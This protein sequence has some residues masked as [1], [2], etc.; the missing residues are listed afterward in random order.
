FRIRREQGLSA[1][2]GVLAQV[3]LHWIEPGADPQ[4]VPGVPGQWQLTADRL[5]VTWEGEQLRLLTGSPEVEAG[6]QDGTQ[7]AT[8]LSAAEVRLARL[9]DAAEPEA[10][11]RGRRTAP[12]IRAP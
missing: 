12:R 4:T 6:D 7:R 3:A 11:R 10:L 2:H 9:G 1:P 8:V 5:T